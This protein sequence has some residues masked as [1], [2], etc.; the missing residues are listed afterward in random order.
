MSLSNGPGGGT[1]AVGADSTAWLAEGEFQGATVNL[2]IRSASGAPLGPREFRLPN[3]FLLTEQPR[4]AAGDGW[5]EVTW[6]GL[7]AGTDGTGPVRVHSV[8]CTVDTCGRVQT[9]YAGQ[10]AQAPQL[11]VAAVGNRALL[12]WEGFRSSG[13]RPVYWALSDAAGRYGR[14]RTLGAGFIGTAL[15]ATSNGGAVAAWVNHPQ[16]APHRVKVD[17]FNGRRWSRVTNAP[18]PPGVEPYLAV[19]DGDVLLAWRGGGLGA[20]EGYAA[21]SVYVARQRAGSSRFARPQRVLACAC[22]DLSFAA[23]P[24]VRAVLAFGNLGRKNLATAKTESLMT[25]LRDPN[26]AFSAPTTVARAVP[27]YVDDTTAVDRAGTATVA[28]SDNQTTIYAAQAPL[29]QSFGA[30]S[31][32]GSGFVPAAQPLG[33][34]TLLAWQRLPGATQAEGCCGYE[35]ALA[36]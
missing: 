33:L 24:A 2:S 28:W 22:R 29:S 11:Q 7:S 19:A 8:R 35:A 4:V 10:G 25:S 13:V 17:H 23:S 14:V 20:G 5:A 31:R 9:V 30:P 36:P 12:L 3:G 18:G 21:G 15:I 16:R 34:G 27:V 6:M 26:A 32:V 1:L